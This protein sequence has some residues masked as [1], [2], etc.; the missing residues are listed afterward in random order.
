MQI[1]NNPNRAINNIKTARVSSAAEARSGHVAFS[2]KTEPKMPEDLKPFYRK[3]VIK[4]P[5]FWERTAYILGGAGAIVGAVALTAVVFPP[6]IPVVGLAAGFGITWYA[7]GKTLPQWESLNKAM[8]K[9]QIARD[10][11]YNRELEKYNRQQKIEKIKNFLLHP[12]RK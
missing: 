5:G 10:I 7:V 6:A 11:K 8:T 1:Y 12:F 9:E 4:D 3:K 2:G